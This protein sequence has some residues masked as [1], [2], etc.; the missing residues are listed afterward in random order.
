MRGWAALRHRTADM[1]T[2]VAIGSGTAFVFSAVVTVAPGVFEKHGVAADVYFDSVS[3]ILALVLLGNALE[4]R[5]RT[6]TSSAIRA[7]AALAPRTARVVRDGH[8]VD[9]EVARVAV[10]DVLS[11]RPGER[12][13]VD[14]RVREGAR[15]ST[16]RCSPASRCRSRSAPGDRWSAARS[17]A[18]ARCSSSP[19]ASARTR[20]WPRSSAW[21]EH[22]QSTRAPM[23]ALADRISAVFVPVVLCVAAVAFVV[24]YDAGPE[25]RLLHAVIA[26]V[27]VTVIACPCAMGLATP[28]A[29]IV[30]MGR[31]ASQGV[32]VKSGEALERAASVDTVVLDK[33]G[34]ITEGRPVLGEIALAE[35]GELSTRRPCLRWRRRSSCGASTRSR[36]RSARRR[37]SAASRRRG[38]ALLRGAPA[39]ASA[40]ASTSA[41]SPWGRRAGSRRSG[42]IPPPSRLG[43]RRWRPRAPRRSWSRSTAGSSA[44]LAV[45]DRVREGARAAVA[46]LRCDGPARRDPHGDRR[47][48]G[49]RG[50][51]RGGRGRGHRRAAP[52]RGSSRRSIA[53]AARARSVA[54]VGDGINDAPALARATVGVAVG[55]GT[56]VA[57]EAADVALLRSGLDGVPTLLALSRRTM[58]TIRENLFWAFAYNIV[59]IPVAAGVLYP[60]F[61][62]LLSPVL[63]SVAMALSS[64]SVVLNSLRLKGFRG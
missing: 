42:S 37:G 27:T 4:G 47:E 34:T 21:C 7:L 20:C 60:P 43:R 12:I 44:A 31:G 16:S 50:R 3:F 35:G 17:T 61:G 39:A 52:R 64:V 51:T 46:R 6:R 58:R 53:C 29:L 36:R 10:G 11:V 28:T 23:Q 22:A 40:A 41:T 45:R 8:E 57:I 18:R 1:N 32:L 56:D 5:A 2:L 19:S 49:G 9:V 14:G 13:P 24:W 30:G 33:T 63:A 59:G 38:R 54:M 15:R 25:P 48:R 26:F 55:G 62:L